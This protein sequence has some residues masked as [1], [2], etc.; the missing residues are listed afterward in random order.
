M[1][2]INR[3]GSPMHYIEESL[4]ESRDELDRKIQ[5]LKRRQNTKSPFLVGSIDDVSK[6]VSRLDRKLQHYTELIA[7][8]RA[9]DY[10]EDEETH[11]EKAATNTR[12]QD[13]LAREK[14]AK[15]ATQFAGLYAIK[16][17][18]GIGTTDKVKKIS[19]VS[20]SHSKTSQTA[21]KET[22]NKPKFVE[23]HQFPGYESN[24]LTPLPSDVHPRQILEK[25]TSAQKDLRKKPT[26]RQTFSKLFSSQ[27]SQAI[28]VDS[29]WW[30]FL[31]KFQKDG[32][33]QQKL[34]NR[35]A[36]NYVKLILQP[37]E[38]KEAFLQSYPSLLAQSV[39]ATFCAAFPDS[40]R[41]FNDDF[42]ENL[43]CV[44]SLWVVGLKPAPK[45]WKK[46]NL[47]ELEPANIKL[48]EEM[49]QN[50]N[51]PSKKSSSTM[52]F[53]L[54]IPSH[55][56][57]QTTL[58]SNRSTSSK[59]SS[60][61]RSIGAA[62]HPLRGILRDTDEIETVADAQN[63]HQKRV[64]LR[65]RGQNIDELQP[66]DEIEDKSSYHASNSNKGGNRKSDEFWN[67]SFKKKRESHPACK[68]PDF[69]K[70]VFNIR[71][72]SPLVAQVMRM[73]NLRQQSG[74]DIKIQRTEIHNL[75]PEG[76]R[77]YMDLIQESFKG[78][79]K[80]SKEFEQMYE[81]GKKEW[82]SYLRDYHRKQKDK[83]AKESAFLANPREVKRI[84][85]L[86]ILEQRKDQ[87]SV[88]AGADLA[89]EAALMAQE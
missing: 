25:V 52:T 28:L 41:Q 77:T 43:H 59:H 73:K 83:M 20:L 27:M 80:R 12:I 30:Y 75:P 1:A 35:I 38:M 54:D 46:W 87:D 79:T 44:I 5:R 23:L 65:S 68:G 60:T 55:H 11:K 85:N 2:A 33:V 32:C 26:Y 82:G 47:D 53:D 84:S 70:L 3:V 18:L 15:E 63:H 13:R 48:R 51:K 56:S 29:F 64:L 50:K 88:T 6:R 8:S 34:F 37:A 76:S 69:T 86:I 19:K 40:Y 31:E 61:H 14:D 24:E 78:V 89:L 66:D 67:S 36:H 17:T 4:E 21:K 72:Q 9:S 57:S 16:S 81:N 10:P 42:K 22:S 39:Y 58:N 45:S 74:C 71:G 62:A 49:M 7:E